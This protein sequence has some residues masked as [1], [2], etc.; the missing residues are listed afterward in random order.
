LTSDKIREAPVPPPSGSASSPSDATTL[1][2][3]LNL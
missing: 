2:R 1:G 3:Y